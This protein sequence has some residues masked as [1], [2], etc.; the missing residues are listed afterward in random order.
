MHLKLLRT[1]FYIGLLFNFSCTAYK[2]VPYFKDINQDTAVE[3]IVNYKPLL[4]RSGDIISIHV[5]SMN[6]PADAI[7]N[8]NGEYKL[9]KYSTTINA[10][11]NSADNTAFGYLVDSEGII[12]L[13]YINK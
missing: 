10:S 4:I 9:D 12:N 7:F 8:S 6:P 2:N 11:D 13:P 1:I 5:S 3:K